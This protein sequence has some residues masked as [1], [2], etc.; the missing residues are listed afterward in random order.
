MQRKSRFP[1]YPASQLGPLLAGAIAAGVFVVDTFTTVETAIAVLYVIVVLLAANVLQRRGIL[2]VGSGCAALTVIGYLWSHGVSADSALVRCLV[3]LFAIAVATVLALRNR[4]AAT[5]LYGQA[6]LLDLTHDAIFVRSMSDV[7]TYWNRGA[8]ELYGWS[9]EEAVGKNASGLL[10]TNFPEA[11]DAI[12]A[13]LVN[14]DRWEGELVHTRRDG[15]QV[16][17]ASRWSLQRD[18][19]GQ[20]A[21]VLETNTDITE[22]KRAAEEIEGAGR[23]LQATID[24]IPAIVASYQADGTRDFV[25]RTWLSYA[26]MSRE[27]A[28]QSNWSMTVHPEDVEAAQ[29]RWSD[30]L[31]T[32]QPFQM[33]LRLLRADGEFRWHLVRRVPLRDDQGAVVKWYGVGFDIEDRKR[34]E[35]ALR[36][37]EA[38]SAE[39]QL[40][41]QTGSFGWR[42]SDGETTWSKEIYRILG[43]DQT[44]RA[45]VKRV[46]D[47]VH[48][49]DVQF[50]EHQLERAKRGERDFDFEHRV[51]MPDGKVKELR[52]RAHRITYEAG[53]EEVVGAVMDVTGAKRAQEALHE[54]QAELAH[55]TRVTTLGE[56]TAS[57]A[58]EVNQPLAGIVTNAEASLR[59]L[60]HAPPRLDEVGRSVERIIGNAD[61]ASGVIRR[62]RDLAKKAT[63]EMARLDINDVIEEA[64]LLVQ[65]EALSNRMELRLAL[66]SDL[67]PVLGDRVQLQQVI[68]NLAING[69]EAMAS[70]N[71][72][73]RRLAIRSHL[74]EGDRVLV[75]VQDFG[76]G[77]DPENANRLFSAFYT[78]KAHGMG[79]GLSIS[80]SII[81]A[82]GGRIWATGDLGSGATF[83]FTLP[84]AAA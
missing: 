50:V 3:S 51:V 62:I 42:L 75:S 83:Q 64:L 78:T 32:S 84:T 52:V 30:C 69:M 47:R 63:P 25:N 54:A 4:A 38:H 59:W 12:A 79:M 23:R 18:R 73:P 43:Y 20:P 24:T 16:A 6:Q 53:V 57:I 28:R 13:R 22:R 14:A 31:A 58:H 5:A 82:H 11:R 74:H 72:R 80:R 2:L 49:D 77:I 15:T 7:I 21:A 36:R 27:A 10:Q 70:I 48:P 29:Q 19:R 68:I 76:V 60:A 41:S 34:A 9:T 35:A 71:D 33:E 8:E 44:V 66:A 61:R 1:T 26:G 55:A 17:V 45:S 46:F 39:A 37:S 56:L 67:P 40:L 65:R 81:E